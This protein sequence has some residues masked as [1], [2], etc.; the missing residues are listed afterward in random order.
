M[1][2]AAPASRICSITR[3]LADFA[4]SPSR[5]AKL[6]M[7]LSFA[8]LPSVPA[9]APCAPI[10]SPASTARVAAKAATIGAAPITIVAGADADSISCG[11][12]PYVNIALR[13][14]W[15]GLL[16]LLTTSSP[17]TAIT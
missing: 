9:S 12:N 10:L 6:S 11:P 13:R 14:D 17:T 5:L 2:T 3:E 4:N 7:R 8:D 16:T 1:V 15:L